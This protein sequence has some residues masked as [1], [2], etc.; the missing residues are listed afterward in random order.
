MPCANVLDRSGDPGTKDGT[1]RSPRG[2]GSPALVRDVRPARI[3]R[4]VLAKSSSWL[5]DPIADALPLGVLQ[6]REDG[7][8]A[9]I[10]FGHGTFIHMAEG[11]EI[12]LGAGV[13]ATITALLHV[14]DL[15]SREVQPDDGRIA[16]HGA[17]GPCTW[18]GRSAGA[19]LRVQAGEVQ[20]D[21][22]KG[23]CH[24]LH[25]L[26]VFIAVYLSH[27]CAGR[28]EERCMRQ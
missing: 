2:G 12:A 28:S 6:G 14:P 22:G 4:G 20:D 24:V 8:D 23:Q 15:F 26:E 10:V 5:T 21:Q 19:V 17:A 18:L 3:G 1:D 7:L 25:L 27:H 16:H 13:P 9:L 11:V